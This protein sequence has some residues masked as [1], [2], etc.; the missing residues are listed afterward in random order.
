[1]YY[2]AFNVH[3]DLFHVLDVTVS[4]GLDAGLVYLKSKRLE[5]CL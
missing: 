5:T 1:M 2:Y 3:N 4:M